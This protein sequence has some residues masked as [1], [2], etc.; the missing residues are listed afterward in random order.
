M[1]DSTIPFEEF[2]RQ[3]VVF[4]Q[5]G[6][7]K[8]ALH[9]IETN[10]AHLPEHAPQ[11][12]T[13]Q[14]AILSRLARTDE[15]IQALY[16]MDQAGLWCHEQALMSDPDF[17]ALH[18][19]PDFSGLVE[20]FKNRR[21]AGI[22]NLRPSREILSP[23]SPGPHPLFLVLHG[24]ESNQAMT[25]PNWRPLVDLGWKL[26][27]LQSSQP[28]WASGIYSWNNIDQSLSE[29]RTH[30][31]ELVA[32]PDSRSKPVIAG[33]F[34]MGA[35]ISVRMALEP[36]FS[37]RGIIAHEPWFSDEAM[38]ELE[39]RLD[40]TAPTPT[41]VMIFAGKEYQEMAEKVLHLLEDHGVT[42]RLI[43]SSNVIHA[44]PAEFADLLKQAVEWIMA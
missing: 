25:L 40:D 33:G 21:V 28:G 22:P 27:V 43:R 26:A 34:S 37:L 12:L 1:E 29:I 19:H 2:L 7:F 15:A 14:C 35:H 8:D 42:C 16:T 10:K 44:Y 3:F 24:N 6:A 30:I 32:D 11:I 18:S 23:A 38:L 39:K 13:W 4:Y 36:G 41:R 5:Q 17:E 20:R 31:S 9:L